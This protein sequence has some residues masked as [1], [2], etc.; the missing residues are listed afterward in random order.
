MQHRIVA[1]L[2]AVT[3]VGSLAS[4]AGAAQT[5]G[6]ILDINGALADY[7]GN[8]ID[9]ALD[10]LIVDARPNDRVD[11]VVTMTPSGNEASLERK[12]GPIDVGRRFDLIRG[13][14]ARMTVGQIR[15]LAHSPGVFRIEPDSSVSIALEGSTSEF[16]TDTARSTY[17]VDGSGIKICISDTG[18]NPNHEQLNNGKVVGF[19]DYVGGLTTAYDDQGHGTHVANIAAGDGMG[20]PS[21]AAHAGVAPGASILA[22]KTLDSTG[23]GDISNIVASLQWCVDQGADVI[24]LSIG[25]PEGSDGADAMSQGVDSVTQTYDIPVVVAAGN[26]GDGAG[27]INSPGTAA[28]AITV[29]AVA[30]SV[31]VPGTSSWSGG[32]HLAGFSSRGPTATNL[33][34]PDVVAPG[35]SVSAAN[36][37][38]TNGY[39]VLSGTSMATPFVA[40]T[41]AL[42]LERDPSLSAGAIKALITSTAQDRGVPGIDNNWGAGLLDGWAVVSAAGNNT[43]S[44][45]V[46]PRN[47]NG[48][49]SVSPN[50][51]WSHEFGLAIGDMTTPIGITVLID[52]EAYC[53]IFCIAP[54]WDPDLEA[55]LIDPN[56]NQIDQSLCPSELHCGSLFVSQGQQ[57]TID[58]MPTVPGTYRLEV[59]PVSS[60]GSF[61]YDISAGLG[62]T[63]PPDNQPPVADAGPDQTVV[64][65]GDLSEFVTLD[66]SASTDDG[67]IVSHRWFENNS[68]FATGVTPE[69]ELSVGTHVITLVVTD[70]LGSVDNDVVEVVVLPAPPPNVAPNANA[71]PD[72]SVPDTKKKGSE[73]VRLDGSGSTDSDGAIV[74][75][76]WSTGSSTVASGENPRVTLAT[77]THTIM[78]V[79]VDDEG[80]T[81]SD[82]VTIAVGETLPTD[83]PPNAN[84]GS[85]QTVIDDDLSEAAWVTLDGSASSDDNGIATYSWRLNGSE[86]ATGVS[87]SVELGLGVHTVTLLVTDSAGNSDTDT[88]VITVESLLGTF[89]MHVH[90][91]DVVATSTGKNKWTATIDIFVVGTDLENNPTL[92]LVV[93][94]D[95]STVTFQLSTGET[96]SCT[97]SSGDPDQEGRC[98]VTTPEM[99]RR[100]SS[101]TVTVLSITAPGFVYGPGGNHDVDGD[102]DGTS[103]TIARP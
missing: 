13:F 33:T 96:M 61:T 34:K 28:S 90:D 73:A 57:E 50:G 49:G 26:S 7:D 12:A 38:V 70:N 41:V 42:A 10:A 45:N 44:P 52:G 29:G 71:G 100:V 86:I 25:A 3:L 20:G 81:S 63:P 36:S 19:I 27:S 79:V 16:G 46:F 76:T 62:S 98:S 22:A 2:L 35:V 18:V 93:G 94:A 5:T 24:S 39:R 51:V 53:G 68:E 31:G 60:G 103:I 78:L 32:I 47:E 40:G 72:Q 14:E 17:G 65:D 102:S 58:V 43:Y 84:A 74:S 37:I 1:V 4:A 83:D 56:G 82:T 23:N 101:L 91:L 85:D 97:T 88:V 9:D 66:G 11:V 59:W 67:S 8:G 15:G 89:D 69:V 99:G 30:E 21:A 48:N 64:D 92:P 6:E 87:P 95:P 80:A 77:G 54:E 55:R 75:W